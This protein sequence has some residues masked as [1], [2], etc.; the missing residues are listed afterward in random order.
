M[1]SRCPRLS[2][3]CWMALLGKPYHRQSVYLWIPTAT[4]PMHPF[5]CLTFQTFLIGPSTLSRSAL[6][7]M[8]HTSFCMQAFIFTHLQQAFYA[9]PLP[10][11]IIDIRHLRIPPNSPPRPIAFSAI[12]T[13]SY[14]FRH[15]AFP[16][17]LPSAARRHALPNV[18]PSSS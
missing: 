12:F 17:L 4:Y 14:L 3:T 6:T 13:A 5:G 8:H 10:F 16:V 2:W 15:G 7:D 9:T 18:D 11:T 1:D